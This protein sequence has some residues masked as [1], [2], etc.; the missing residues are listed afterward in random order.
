MFS[1]FYVFKEPTVNCHGAEVKIGPSIYIRVFGHF[2]LDISPSGEK[3]YVYVE[4][5]AI[6]PTSI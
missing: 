2:P 5:A 6:S 3:A 1:I 4:L